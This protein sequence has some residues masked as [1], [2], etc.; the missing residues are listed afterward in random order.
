MGDDA[1]SIYENEQRFDTYA[2]GIDEYVSL[3]SFLFQKKTQ[4]MRI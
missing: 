1:R 4:K 2:Q 3:S